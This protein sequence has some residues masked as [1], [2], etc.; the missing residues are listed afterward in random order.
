MLNLYA[1]LLNFSADVLRLAIWLAL[2]MAV[3]VPLERVFALHPAKIWRKQFGVD[4]VWY[5]IN[6]LFPA[7][8]VA[9]ALSGVTQALHRFNPGG[10]YSAVAA[11]PFWVR[12]PLMLF[13]SDFGVYW[14]H[15]ALHQIPLLWRFHAIHH[16]AEEMDWLVNTRAHPFDMVLVRVSGLTPMY[17][18][19]L[20]T[21]PATS[22]IDP[23][24]AL[25]MIVSV[26]W[27]F[28]IH[29]NVR[30]RLGPLEALISS[31]MFHHWHHCN[32]EHRHT[33]YAFVFPFIDRIFGTIWMPGYWPAGYGVDEKIS[34]TV[35]G[36]F[37]DPIEPAPV[38]VS[39]PAEAKT[40]A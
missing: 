4:L 29:S 23:E 20:A 13:V 15:R 34:T 30:F 1:Q 6:T 27:N 16:S 3:F 37:L 10:Y 36:Q 31:P 40:D 18:L 25:V 35:I 33:N 26:L 11:W 14:G 2:L 22:T 19:G 12:L 9:V 5:F 38:R 7:T 28:F 17:L 32:D 21:V 8:V 39:T 24:V